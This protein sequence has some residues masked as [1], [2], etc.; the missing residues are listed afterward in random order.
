VTILDHT[1][2]AALQRSQLVAAFERA[3]D[4]G[5]AETVVKE[6]GG[7]HW[8]NRLVELRRRG[9][10]IGEDKGVFVLVVGPG[11][12]R[13]DSMGGEEERPSLAVGSLDTPPDTL[14]VLPPNPHYREAA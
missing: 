9:F 3:G 11:V 14:F 6:I 4:D 7:Y 12:E 8:H 10:V 5:L 13:A 1:G 2:A